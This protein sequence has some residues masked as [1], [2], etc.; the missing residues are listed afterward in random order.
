MWIKVTSSIKL[1]ANAECL[2]TWLYRI[3]RNTA[4]S[5]MRNQQ[6]RHSLQ[7]HL[8]EQ[9]NDQEDELFNEDAIKPKDVHRAL[10]S[11]PL[12][13]REALTLYYLEDFSIQEIADVLGHP[14]GTVKSRL[15][16]AKRA[17]KQLLLNE[18]EAHV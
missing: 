8:E 15:H 5:H 3:A 13:F 6:A 7:Q 9:W 10:S 17:L 1:L 14:P 11:L 18:E 12:P 2:P 4:I 16:Y